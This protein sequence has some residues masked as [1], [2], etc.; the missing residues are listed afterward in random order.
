MKNPLI[1]SLLALVLSAAALATMLVN[2]SATEARE[3]APLLPIAA[4]EADL[5][6]RVESLGEENREL[7]DQ[8]A[9]LENEL[10][11]RIAT[12]EGREDSSARVPV[13]GY[14]PVAEFEAL[15]DE[16]RT[17]LAGGGALPADSPAFKE[18]VADTIVDLKR[19]QAIKDSQKNL[20][21]RSGRL[22]EQLPDFAEKLGLTHLQESE[23]QK[24]LG[25]H[26]AKEAQYGVLYAEGMPRVEI[27]EQKQDDLQAL[28]DAL[29]GILS[30]AQLQAYLSLQG[31]EE[32]WLF[33]KWDTGGGR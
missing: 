17:A 24:A 4:P 15:R 20:E 5:V 19:E 29:G 30:P 23:M 8:V 12:L 33:P 1:V 31:R 16:M 21:N 6:A 18:Q 25:A 22:S 13:G 26:Y 28:S 10:L 27:G 7:R 2:Q 14:V 11:D 9:M 3:G 32:G